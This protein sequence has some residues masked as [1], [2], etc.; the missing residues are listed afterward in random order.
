MRIA[1]LINQYPMVSHSFIRREIMALERQGFEVIRIAIRGWGGELVNED[2]RIERA[3]TRYVLQDGG[4]AMALAMVRMMVGRPVCLMRAALLAWKMSRRADRPFAI[5]LI[6]LMEACRIALWLKA[7]SVAHL[8]AHFGTNSAQVALMIGALDGPPWS[9]T[10]HGPEEF[11]KAPAIALAEKMRRCAF[12]VAISSYGRSQ[13]YRLLERQDWGKV[14]VIHCGLERSYFDPVLGPPE[15]YA[16]RLVCVGRLCEQKGQMLLIEAARDLVSR[17]IKFELVLVGD[18][19]M[20]PDI[21]ALIV[22]YDLQSLIRITGWL[23]SDHVREEIAV[24]RALV[25]P[26]FAEGLPVVLMEAMALGRPV[27]STFVAGIPELVQPGKNGWLVPAGDIGA[28]AQAI[29]ACLEAPVKE[30]AA[31]GSAARNR[32]MDRHDVDVE[33]AKLAKL[34]RGEQPDTP[35]G[36]ARSPGPRLQE[37]RGL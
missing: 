3:R 11:D 12:V 4:W 37:R 10:V 30:L 20:R 21:E 6:Y 1:Y 32:V 2:D 24:A 17:G 13:L 22:Q 23:D 7:A 19:E 15:C 36:V 31:M 35:A 14:H 33:S 34:F 9:F 5:H 29:Q 18:G 26:S 28:L 16:K 25:L 8:H 27:V